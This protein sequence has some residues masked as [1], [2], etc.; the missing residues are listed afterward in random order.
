MTHA[1][2]VLDVHP[3][4]YHFQLHKYFYIVISCDMTGGRREG[5]TMA[6]T[7]HLIRLGTG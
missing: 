2:T 6:T 5:L 1:V 4:R 7:S 3:Q